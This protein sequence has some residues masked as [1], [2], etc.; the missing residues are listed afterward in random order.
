M[1]EPKE[2]F[3]RLVFRDMTYDE[4]L[5]GLSRKHETIRPQRSLSSPLL[6]T[7]TV[8]LKFYPSAPTFVDLARRKTSVERVGLR[9]H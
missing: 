1:Y 9:R 5:L 2:F 8:L 7:R 3:N 6:C 4:T